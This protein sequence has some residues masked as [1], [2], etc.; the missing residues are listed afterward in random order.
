M[1]SIPKKLLKK[2]NS[3][4]SMKT[5]NTIYDKIRS[6]MT[7]REINENPIIA[8]AL[9]QDKKII[10]SL[11]T[12]NKSKIISI[13]GIKNEKK[14]HLVEQINKFRKSYFNYFKN[15]KYSMDEITNLQKENSYFIK[16]YHEIEEKSGIKK[17]DKFEEIKK[18]YEKKNYNLPTIEGNKNLFGGS[19]LLSNNETD[20]KK[21]II[22]GVGSENSNKKSISYLNKVNDDINEKAQREGKKTKLIF[23]YI[24]PGN[25]KG[26][27]IVP[28]PFYSYY[29][30]AKEILDYQSEINNLKNCIDSIPEIDYFFGSDNKK[31]LDSL[32]FFDS[33]K[34]SANFSTG[35]YLE[36]TSANMN[37]SFCSRKDFNNSKTNTSN[38]K[39]ISRIT[40]NPDSIEKNRNNK[41]N[42]NP[43]TM[44]SFS[45]KQ[46]NDIKNITQNKIPTLTPILKKPKKKKRLSVAK[47]YK[48]YR[49]TLET[50]YSQVSKSFDTNIFHKNIEK[51]L[52]FRQYDIVPKLAP[53]YLCHNI[54]KNRTQIC[55]GKAMKKLIDLRQNLGDN[56]SNI[57]QLNR[58]EVSTI[59]NMNEMEDKMIKVFSGFKSS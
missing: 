14:Q 5:N 44:I 33:R 49:K 6:Y 30:N 1:I 35:A 53:Y 24:K 20:L 36:R 52:K 28:P 43:N 50:L 31:Y 45:D 40:Y 19:L 11:L 58:N 34:S 48:N 32:K 37:S 26:A 13:K 16:R 4:T 38:L 15:Y 18:A 2:S 39:N 3:V 56:Q 9:T 54:E 23:G 59:K 57:E 10:F 47:T 22:Y 17:Q 7:L 41:I 8:S 25:N 42:C 29:N 27:V 12:Q 21:Y 46:N 55:K 51:Y